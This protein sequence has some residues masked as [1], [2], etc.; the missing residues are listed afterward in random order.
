MPGGTRSTRTGTVPGLL[1]G[2]HQVS[3]SVTMGASDEEDD[4]NSESG[5]DDGDGPRCE[6]EV[7]EVIQPTS[8]AGGSAKS[9]F[10][11]PDRNED[12]ENKAGCDL[13]KPKESVEQIMGGRINCGT[14]RS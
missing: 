1:F 6:D 10:L 12:K 8:G 3:K 14:D 11:L 13:K 4:W 5:E 7:E 9:I 2:L